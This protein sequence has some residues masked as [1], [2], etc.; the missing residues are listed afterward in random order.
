VHLQCFAAWEHERTNF[1]PAG[2]TVASSNRSVSETRPS[3]GTE[4]K[5]TALSGSLPASSNHRMITV[6]ECDGTEERG[7][8]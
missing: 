2:A 3:P 1:E 7:S 8:G 6:H 4:A 5:A